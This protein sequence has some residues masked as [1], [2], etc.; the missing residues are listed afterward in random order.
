MSASSLSPSGGETE[1]I[2]KYQPGVPACGCPAA[3]ACPRPT[4]IW[5][6]CSRVSL[7]RTGPTKLKNSTGAWRLS[8]SSRSTCAW[9][10]ASAAAKTAQKNSGFLSFFII[11]TAPD[12]PVSIA[13]RKPAA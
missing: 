4:P 9:P 13:G 8:S 12:F 3:A 6:I 1:R 2:T 7:R 10:A 11:G 5:R